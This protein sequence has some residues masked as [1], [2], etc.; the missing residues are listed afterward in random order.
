ML[1]PSAFANQPTRISI[2]SPGAQVICSTGLL[3]SSHVVALSAPTLGRR[4]LRLAAGSDSQTEALDLVVPD[5]GWLARLVSLAM[6]PIPLS[7]PCQH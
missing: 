5:E 2:G 1:E 7:T 4:P 3:R 6:A